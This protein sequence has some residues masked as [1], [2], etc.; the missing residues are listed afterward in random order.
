MTSPKAAIERL[1]V[2]AAKLKSPVN[3]MEVCGTHTVSVFRSGMHSLMP[4]NVKLLSGPGCPVC[5][6][7]QGDI[8]LLIDLA[9]KPGVAFFTYGDMLRVTGSSGSLEKAKSA[10]AEVHIAYSP[11]DALKYANENP[12]KEV[13]FGAVGFE[14]TTPA[15]A[16]SILKAKEMGLGNYSVL[17]SHKRVMP[18]MMAL[19]AG[20]KVNVG[21]FMLPG[22]VS[23]L[24][25]SEAYR[26]IVEQYKLPCVIAGFEDGQIALALARLTELVADGKAE[27]END[28]QQ[29]VKKAG[30]DHAMGIIGRVFEPADV[31]WRGIGVIPRSGLCI[32]DE[33]VKFDA[34]SRFGLVAKEMPEPAGCRC[35][36]V[37][38]GQCLPSDCKLFGKTCTPIHA[39]GPCMVSSEGSCQAWFKYHRSETGAR[40]G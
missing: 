6:T 14:T 22:H 17:A 9:I 10:G 24:I 7:S 26:P 27:L 2:A 35:G 13:V 5:V 11:L 4:A 1:N 34:K 3:F 37:I 15:T 31:S 30:N 32:V 21:G 18:A 40:H 12:K 33:F 39:V 23:I 19:L 36:E 16:V 25:G 28:Y 38:T 20:G 8:D 29:V